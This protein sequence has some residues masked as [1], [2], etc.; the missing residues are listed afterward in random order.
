MATTSDYLN[1]LINQKNNLINILL[2]SGASIPDGAT[3]NQL[4]P[5][6]E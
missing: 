1:E 2:D 6:V 4:I 3:F 5:I